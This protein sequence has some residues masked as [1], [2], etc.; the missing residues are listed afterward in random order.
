MSTIA[1]DIVLFAIEQMEEHEIVEI[2]NF[3]VEQ[4][5]N[6]HELVE[7]SQKLEDL[8][9]DKMEPF[10][11]AVYAMH[12]LEIDGLLTLQ[13]KTIKTIKRRMVKERRDMGMDLGCCA[14][15][16]SVHCSHVTKE[17]LDKELDFIEKSN[18]RHTPSPVFQEDAELEGMEEIQHE[19][20]PL[21]DQQIRYLTFTGLQK[22]YSDPME[23]SL[24]ENN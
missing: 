3:A 19:I 2:I 6:H 18:A 14:E 23:N 22:N 5:D 12:Q 15:G 13:K 16:D 21:S 8:T 24:G 7:L 17:M 4:L 1:T 11:S 20:L 10:E 9:T